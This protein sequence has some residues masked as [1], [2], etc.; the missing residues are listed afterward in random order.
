MLAG[1]VFIAVVAFVAWPFV[2]IYVRRENAKRLAVFDISTPEKRLALIKKHAFRYGIRDNGRRTADVDTYVH[3]LKTK[4]FNVT[5][6][7]PVLL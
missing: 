2:T 1:I 7:D 3:T 6:E 4:G 5:S